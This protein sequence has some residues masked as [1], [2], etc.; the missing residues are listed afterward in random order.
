LRCALTH[1]PTL[2]RS[3][4]IALVVGTVL[5]VINQGDILLHRTWDSTLAWKLPLTYL[6]PFV[7]ATWAALG[8]ARAQGDGARPEV[9]G[10]PRDQGST[11]M[12]R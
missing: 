8:G 10:S 3:G 12:S 1:G 7:V 5:T 2:R 6:V 4:R 11:R 9:P